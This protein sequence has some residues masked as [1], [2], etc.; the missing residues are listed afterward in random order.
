MI[1]ILVQHWMDV[2]SLSFLYHKMK[3]W[4]LL[5]CRHV[6]H[7]L[8]LSGCRWVL[9]LGCSTASCRC[10]S[11]QH[12]AWDGMDRNQG[13]TDRC[14]SYDLLNI[15]DYNWL[16]SK[17]LTSELV[18][19]FWLCWSGKKITNNAWLR[20]QASPRFAADSTRLK[21]NHMRVQGKSGSN[22]FMLIFYVKQIWSPD[23]S[24]DFSYQGCLIKS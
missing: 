15:N 21:P 3:A 22:K 9:W 12:W 18:T 11:I 13:L 16:E 17:V 24:P 23:I 10:T 5:A 2:M 4:Q 6:L 1:R 19:A 14:T 7:V 20:W 8:V